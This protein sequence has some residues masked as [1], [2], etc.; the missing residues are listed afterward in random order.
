EYG[1]SRRKLEGRDDARAERERRIRRQRE[2]VE[3][4]AL[5]VANR[6]EHAD[7]ADHAQRREVQRALQRKPQADRPIGAARVVRRLPD[8]LERR[9]LDRKR[10]VVDDRS[11]RKAVLESG[12]VDE[13][14]HRG[15]RL[16]LRLDG[17]VVLVEVII[18]AAGERDDRTVLRI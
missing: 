11:D 8:V 9:V 16:A 18:E 15:A 3:T 10:R 5:E 4:E 2:L 6:I 17:A 7:V 12:R 14:L 13:G 1:I